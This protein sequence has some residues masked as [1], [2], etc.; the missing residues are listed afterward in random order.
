MKSTM[1]R[2]VAVN[3]KGQSYE[4]AQVSA[5]NDNL[6]SDLMVL[7]HYFAAFM[8]VPKHEI[9]RFFKLDHGFEA[10]STAFHALGWSRCKRCQEYLC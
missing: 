8:R 3:N 7:P 2:A 5:D 6:I 4:A 10:G 9:L 1:I